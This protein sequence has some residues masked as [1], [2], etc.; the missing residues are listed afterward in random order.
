VLFYNNTFLP[1]QNLLLPI[2][3]RAFQYNDGF[4]ETIMVING[5]LRFWKE[6]Q[7][8]MRE[9]GHALKLA[10]P[11]FFWDAELEEKLLELARLN[12][13]DGYGRLKLKVWRAG[14]GLYTPQTNAVEWLATVAPAVPIPDT[15]ISIGI[16]ETVRTIFSPLSHF[17][18]PHAP[19]YVLAGVEKQTRGYADMLLLD[20]HGNVAEL[21]SSNIFW[22]KGDILFTPA[23]ETGCVNGILRRSILRWC[24]QQGIAVQQTLARAE[25]LLQAD[26]VFAANVTGLRTL[27]KLEDRQLKLNTVWVDRL[28]QVLSL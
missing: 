18:G 5:Q 20:A 10:I 3:N 13:A 22:I 11:D 1:D 4:F 27:G 2:T 21:I 15:P 28:Q 25:E 23:L 9:A 8:R 26:C 19:L 12:S 24:R 16:G 6:H 7:E 14:A 17:K